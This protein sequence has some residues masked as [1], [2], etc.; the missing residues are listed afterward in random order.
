MKKASSFMVVLLIIIATS[1]FPGFPQKSEEKQRVKIYGRVT[2]FKAQAIE[3][4]TVELKDA[5][6]SNVAT[7]NS[8]PDGRYSLVVPR[9]LYM[10]LAAVKDYQVRSLEYWAWNV[11]A[12]RDVEINPRFDRLEVYG[13]NA[14]RPQGAYPSYQ[15]YFRPMSLSAVV[16]KVTEAGGLENFRGLPVMDIAPALDKNDITVVIDGQNVNVLE[17][18]KVREAAGVHQYMFGYLIQVALP[19][20]KTQREYS[21]ITITLTDPVTGEKG[22]GC[23]FFHTQGLL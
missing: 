16:K 22:E 15:I 13:I 10:A 9:G 1:F 7:T 17:L 4:A 14:W 5:Q 6:F 8:G 19:E 21:V 3:G 20:K 11:P 18:N 12:D 2:N 23:L